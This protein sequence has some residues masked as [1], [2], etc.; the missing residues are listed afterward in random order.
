MVA[1]DITGCGYLRY[2]IPLSRV[3]RTPQPTEAPSPPKPCDRPSGGSN[4]YR[5]LVVR[6]VVETENQV[7]EEDQNVLYSIRSS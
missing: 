4:P 6:H 2:I 1:P 7:M 5:P 3:S